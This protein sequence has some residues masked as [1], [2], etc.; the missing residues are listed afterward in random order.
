MQVPC[1][2]RIGGFE[3]G[4]GEDGPSLTF[5]PPR[6]KS[7]RLQPFSALRLGVPTGLSSFSSLSSLS[8]LSSV[9]INIRLYYFIMCYILSLEYYFPLRNSIGFFEKNVVLQRYLFTY[10]NCFNSNFSCQSVNAVIIITTVFSCI[11]G[12]TNR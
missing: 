5:Q 11:Y 8:S 9:S 2:G 4:V 10:T 6:T 1:P 7:Q 3:S 12:N